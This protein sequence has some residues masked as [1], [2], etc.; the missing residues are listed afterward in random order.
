TQAE[1]YKDACVKEALA[2]QPIETAP[3]N[4]ETLLLGCF[5]SSGNWRTMRGQWMSEGYIVEYWEDPDGAEPGWFE[6]AVEADDIPNC[7]QIT[8]SHWMPLP[9]P[10]TKESKNG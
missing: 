1:A 3:R 4:G 5:N 9:P 10:P 6:T 7:W 8:P 2:W